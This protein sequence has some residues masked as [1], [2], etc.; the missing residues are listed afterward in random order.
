MTT[1][2]VVLVAS[3]ATY[4]V[5]ISMV[6]VFHERSVPAWME[7]VLALAGPAVLAAIVGAAVAAP[8]GSIEAPHRATLVALA[9]AGLAVRRTGK[10]ALALVVGLPVAWIAV[11]AGWA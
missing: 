9:A 3:L 4:L 2:L 1:W 7:S 8:N 11:T 5:R 6:V 10:P